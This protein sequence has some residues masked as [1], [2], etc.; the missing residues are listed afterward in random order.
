MKH[1]FQVETD[2][3]ALE[4]LINE[5]SDSITEKGVQ[6]MCPHCKETVTVYGNLANCPLCHKVFEIQFSL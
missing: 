3:N 2:P 4:Q 1:N 6:V 5:M